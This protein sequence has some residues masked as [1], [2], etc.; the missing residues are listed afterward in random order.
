MEQD[1]KASDY[2]KG[3][4]EGY[5]IMKY[6][7]ALADK[8]AAITSKALRMEGFKD[9]RLEFIKERDLERLPQWMKR[10]YSNLSDRAES[11]GKDLGKE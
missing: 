9:G 2:A 7:P 1:I 6:E 4:N 11:K 5:F 3:F 8:L 10:D